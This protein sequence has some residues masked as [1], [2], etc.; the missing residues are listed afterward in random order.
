ML[1]SNIVNK[2]DLIYNVFISLQ[3]IFAII[4]SDSIIKNEYYFNS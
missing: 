4:I 2:L 3:N 1:N